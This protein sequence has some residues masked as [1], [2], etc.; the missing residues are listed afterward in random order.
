MTMH[1]D[2]LPS[3][4]AS[5]FQTL[6]F[7]LQVR[8]E[9]EAPRAWTQVIDF[10]GDVTKGASGDQSPQAIP[11]SN[12]IW[13]VKEIWSK[14]NKS[15]TNLEFGTNL[16]YENVGYEQILNCDQN[17]NLKILE[18]EQNLTMNIFWVWT[19]FK[20]EQI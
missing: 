5:L 3:G 8:S 10:L 17:W 7:L 6:S 12:K 1:L 15:W 13:I 18:F 2:P 19:N 20:A 16:E 9:L 4:V 14:F 11:F